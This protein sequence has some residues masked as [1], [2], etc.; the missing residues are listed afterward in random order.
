MAELVARVNTLLVYMGCDECKDG[1][2]K[3][4]YTAPVLDSYPPQYTH[5]CDKCGCVKTFPIQYPYNRYV[6]IE[7]LRKPRVGEL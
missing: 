2:M 4:D 7:P 5:V 1:V 6:P 3:I